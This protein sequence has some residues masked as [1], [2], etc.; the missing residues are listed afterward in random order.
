ML[1]A[2]ATEAWQV[3][4]GNNNQNNKMKAYIFTVKE[5]CKIFMWITL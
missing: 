3:A 2:K 4:S 1:P 5:C